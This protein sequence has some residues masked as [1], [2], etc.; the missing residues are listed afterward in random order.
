MLGIADTTTFSLEETA[1]LPRLQHLRFYEVLIKDVDYLESMDQLTSI[2][3]QRTQFDNE[4]LFHQ[5]VE[6][7]GILLEGLNIHGEIIIELP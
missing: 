6:Q 1:D 3:L 7:Q 4:A 2:R 5:L